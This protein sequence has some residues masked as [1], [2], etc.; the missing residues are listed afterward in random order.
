MTVDL[1]RAIDRGWE[2]LMAHRAALRAEPPPLAPQFVRATDADLQALVEARIAEY[3][4][5]PWQA[6]DGTVAWISP[7]LLALYAEYPQGEE[8]AGQRL[9]DGAEELTRRYERL[10]AAAER[11][12]AER[13]AYA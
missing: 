4:P 11:E 1:A 9:V 5:E 7:W 12:E 3:P 6:P 13:G 8:R 2:A 10:T